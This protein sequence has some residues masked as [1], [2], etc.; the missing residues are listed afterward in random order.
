MQRAVCNVRDAAALLACMPNQVY[1]NTEFEGKMV[2]DCGAI[3]EV[4]LG[5]LVLEDSHASGLGYTSAV[6]GIRYTVTGK[7]WTCS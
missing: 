5:L 2:S 6:N 3:T 4:V 1:T 7:H